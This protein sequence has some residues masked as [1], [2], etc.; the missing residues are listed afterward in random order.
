MPVLSVA[1]VIAARRSIRRFRPQPLEDAQVQ[2]LLE[3]ARLAP[4]AINCQPWRFKVV[5][6]Q[7]TLDWL[8]STGTRNQRWVGRAPVVFVCCADLSCFVKDQEANLRAIADSGAMP[9]DMLAEVEAYVSR[10]ACAA[11]EMLRGAAAVNCGIALTQMMLQAVALGL[12]STWVGMFD[13]PAIKE[14][15]GLHPDLA[16][17][18][19]LA[20]GVPSET[21]PPRPRR[22][23]KDILLP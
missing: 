16:V 9:P 12:G 3:A 2:A 1:E 6:D 18:A 13:E 11:P 4:S 8:A 19:L 22:E 20:V 7:E 10:N 21:P 17:I 23:L 5:R 15:F 14:R